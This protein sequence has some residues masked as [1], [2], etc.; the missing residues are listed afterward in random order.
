MTPHVPTLSEDIPHIPRIHTPAKCTMPRPGP[1]MDLTPTHLPGMRVPKP[2]PSV[3]TS[4]P[5]DTNSQDLLERGWKWFACMSRDLYLLEGMW[6]KQG[7]LNSTPRA[8]PHHLVSQDN[9]ISAITGVPRGDTWTTR[10]GSC[11]ILRYSDVYGVCGVAGAAGKGVHTCLQR[12]AG[13]SLQGG[14]GGGG[15]VHRAEWA[16]LKAPWSPRLQRQKL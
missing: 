1:W 16:E 6:A 9:T 4:V 13:R 12:S 3:P 15:C 8:R 10:I 11:P 14:E 7:Q 5:S 2:I